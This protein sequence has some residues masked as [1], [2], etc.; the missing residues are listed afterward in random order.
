MKLTLETVNDKLRLQLSISDGLGDEYIDINQ[1]F[2]KKE[3]K[4]YSDEFKSWNEVFP[5]QLGD[6]VRTVKDTK[7]GVE[8]G[9]VGIVIEI[10]VSDDLGSPVSYVFASQEEGWNG[11]FWDGCVC[12]PDEIELVEQE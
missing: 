5:F 9:K 7:Y 11:P 12:D 6:H 10:L 2:S 1:L 3:W 4:A 8:A